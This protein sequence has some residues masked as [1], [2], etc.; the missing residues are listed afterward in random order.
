MARVVFLGRLREAAGVRA[1]DLPLPTPTTLEGLI[2]LLDARDPGIG[3][4]LTEP[5]VRVAINKA[6]SPA[7]AADAVTDADEIAFL[8]P[9]TG[10]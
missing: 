7:S 4:V 6:L 5:S 2:G 8:P 9:V 3:A 1:L 10:G